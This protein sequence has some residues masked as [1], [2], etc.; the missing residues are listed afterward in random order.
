MALSR[1]VGVP[2]RA[3]TVLVALAVA[4]VAAFIVGPRPL[5]ADGSGG[6]DD[7]RELADAAGRAFDGYW[8]SGDRAFSPDLTR[9]VDYWFRYHVAKAAFA[10]ILLIVLVA[11]GVLLWRAFLRAGGLGAGGRAALAS[12]GVLVTMLA[13]FSLVAVMANIQGAAAPFASL[14][15][16][17]TVG[18]TG[19]DP[20]D[21]LGQVRQRLADLHSGPT[22]PA[23]EAMIGDFSR[24]HAVMAVVAAIVAVVLVGMSVVSWR[25]FARTGSSER[26]SRRV[27]GSF[28]VFSALSALVVIFVAAANTTTAADPAPA[29]LAFF[30]GGW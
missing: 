22:P 8:R 12:A 1:S 23:L 10:A 28:G 17:A 26:R 15:P 5:A 11:L 3:L 4:L 30:N 7:E 14:L 16:M 19:G 21:T 25:R 18:A 20:A 27:A 24:F 9:V 6:F 13:L 2:G 29:L